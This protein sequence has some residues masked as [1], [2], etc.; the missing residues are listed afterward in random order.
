MSDQATFARLLSIANEVTDMGYNGRQHQAPMTYRPL[1]KG[2]NL[3]HEENP[4]VQ[5]LLNNDPHRFVDTLHT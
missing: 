5:I 4:G 3:V 2:A 1:K